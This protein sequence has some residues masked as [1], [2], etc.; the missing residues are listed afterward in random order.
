MAGA[1]NLEEEK[2]KKMGVAKDS[3]IGEEHGE[4]GTWNA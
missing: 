3:R 4:D 2:G 1:L